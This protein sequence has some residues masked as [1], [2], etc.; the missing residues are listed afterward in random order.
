MLGNFRAG[1]F[2][3]GMSLVA[4]G[5]LFA[6]YPAPQGY[7]PTPPPI[8]PYLNLLRAGSPTAINYYGLVRPELEFRSSLQILEQGLSTI[9]A[10]TAAQTPGG[11][12]PPTGHPVYFDNQSHYFGGAGASGAG[13]HAAGFSGAPQ[14]SARR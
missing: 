8:S 10:E 3:L 14:R 7:R 2:S 12:P 5:Q 9:S 4:A 11:A 1:M 13:A 6:Q